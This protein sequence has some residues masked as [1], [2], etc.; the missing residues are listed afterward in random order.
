MV[1][2]GVVVHA[3]WAY[4]IANADPEGYVEFNP[5][6]LAAVF[7]DVKR[8]EIERAIEFLCEP[9]QES[10]T[11][12][13]EGRRLVRTAE[14]EWQLVN[15]RQFREMRSQDLRRMQN[16]DAKRRQRDREKHQ[17]TDDKQHATFETA[18]P[19]AK[20]KPGRP[21]R[22]TPPLRCGDLHIKTVHDIERAAGIQTNSD[23]TTSLIHGS[24][25]KPNEF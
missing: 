10:R 2:K 8:Q 1:G 6:I 19:Y 15:Y 5:G 7:G 21:K 20:R 3:V 23:G 22:A 24:G 14:Y 17:A 25:T 9:D 16:R 18:A 4:C 11:K 12:T 13:S